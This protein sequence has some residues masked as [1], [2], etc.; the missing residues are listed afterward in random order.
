MSSF[1][2]MPVAFVLIFLKS[3]QQ[4]NVMR[5]RYLWVLPISYC[6]ALVE[7]VIWIQVVSEGFGI[8]IFWMGTGA[9]LGC[10]SGMYVHKRLHKK[11]GG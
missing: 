3:F 2:L 4:L 11:Y 6:M 8:G 1:L 10:I 7:A 9:G 5:G